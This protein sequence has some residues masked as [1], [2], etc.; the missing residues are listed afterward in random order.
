[1][2]FTK[3]CMRSATCVY[4][5]KYACVIVSAQAFTLMDASDDGQLSLDD[6]HTASREAGLRCVCVRARVTTCVC[7]CI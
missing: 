6:L 2:M 7:V 4:L 5:H 1:M 3:S